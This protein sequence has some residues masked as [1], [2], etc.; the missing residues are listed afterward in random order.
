MNSDQ[1][2]DWMKNLYGTFGKPPPQFHVTTAAYDRVCSLPDEF[3]RYALEKLQ[4]REV[5]PQ[6]LG[7]ELRVVLWPDFL[8]VHP[9]LRSHADDCPECGGQGFIVMT[10]KDPQGRPGYGKTVGFQCVCR[11]GMDEGWTYSRIKQAGYE[12][13]PFDNDRAVRSRQALADLGVK[14]GAV[15]DDRAFERMQRL[16]D[17]ERYDYTADY[18]F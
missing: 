12:Q 7:R 9:E 17:A 6:N 16:S 13:E 15:R 8:S 4:D 1:F 11:A 10:L 2:C 3:F 18:P 5:L 14:L